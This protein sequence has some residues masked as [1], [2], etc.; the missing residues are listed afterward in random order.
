MGDLPPFFR[1]ANG[2]WAKS[3]KLQCYTYAYAG[4]S[5]KPA[6]AFRECPRQGLFIQFGH[7]AGLGLDWAQPGDLTLQ[8]IMLYSLACAQNFEH[9]A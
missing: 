4:K 2:R 6:Q 1:S 7:R 5:A 3:S 8:L 9:D